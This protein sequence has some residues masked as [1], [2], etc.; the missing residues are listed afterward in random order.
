MSAPAARAAM[1]SL[2]LFGAFL[3]SS[4]ERRTTLV[5]RGDS[6]EVASGDTARAL[7]RDVQRAWE[8]RGDLDEAAE[9]TATLLLAE[10]RRLDPNSWVDRT[11][12][13][14]DSLGIGV[15]TGGSPCGLAVN[16][17]LRSD[18]GAGSWPFLFWC[19]GRDVR[20]H[21]LEGRNLRLLGAAARSDSGAS[22][23]TSFA[24][25]YARSR[26][27]RQEP[28]LMVWNRPEK[29]DWRLM[30]TLGPDS[31]GGTGTAELKT[32]RS[33]DVEVESRTYR[34]P[35]G[36]EECPTC[37]HV[38][39]T[40]RFRWGLFGF[41]RVEDAAVPSAYA[42]FVQFILAL[43]RGASDPALYVTDPA[44][45]DEALR[46][47]WQSM[48]GVWRIAP[49][50]EEAGSELTFFRGPQEA[51]RVR[52]VPRDDQYLIAGFEVVQRTVE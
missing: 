6:T 35:Q 49:K 13:L 44:L 33:A 3:L 27:T 20:M 36:F 4:C 17:F 46:L 52:F 21:A 28:L 47:D 8:Q 5:A 31:L 16:L 1:A 18:P 2:L 11:E 50:S 51:Y 19:T 41:E 14:C 37:P 39:W 25:L 38:Y 7:V 40:H 23:Y 10:F 43:S 24:A 30:Q 34:T 9:M 15:E 42:T 29:G 12:A 45:I 48:R 22:D 26:G 32:T